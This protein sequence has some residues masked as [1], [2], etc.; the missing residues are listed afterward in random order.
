MKTIFLSIISLIFFSSMVKSQ[1]SYSD[2]GSSS[3][4]VFVNDQFSNNDNDWYIEETG[5]FIRRIEGGHLYLEST[6]DRA[7]LLSN[8]YT[9]DESRNYQIEASLKFI[10]GKVNT[11]HALLFG[12]SPDNDFGFYFTGQQSYK[13]SK[14]EGGYVDYIDFTTNTI[15]STN[16]YNKLTLRKVGNQWYFFINEQLVH[17]MESQT[18]FGN[19]IGFQVGGK[20][21]IHVDYLTIHYL[22]GTSVS[23]TAKPKIPGSTKTGS[24]GSG[25]ASYGWIYDKNV[26][27][28]MYDEFYSNTNG[29]GTGVTT[30][31][32]RKIESGYYFFQTFMESFY[33]TTIVY[34]FEKS[35]NFQLETILKIN[36]GSVSQE[37]GLIWSMENKSSCRFGITR[38]GEYTIYNMSEG[39]VEDIKDFTASSAIKKS[40]FNLLTIRKYDGI[41]YFFINEQLVHQCNYYPGYGDRIGFLVGKKSSLQIDNLKIS[42]ITD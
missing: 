31:V 16:G 35:R 18:F 21:I 4:E 3:K 19:R 26:S 8:E 28:V 1:S 22:P 11:G 42:Y 40:D 2:Y 20:S 9:I 6:I 14:Y 25:A 23:G 38:N 17:T 37:N 39:S 12:K 32:E 13:I 33:S 36:S 7:K 10:T 15:L 5:D 24:T 30:D 27:E 34:E 29:W 41:Y